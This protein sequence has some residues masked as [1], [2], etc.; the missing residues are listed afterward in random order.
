MNKILSARSSAALFESPGMQVPSMASGWG[1]PKIW[2][3]WASFWVFNFKGLKL[4]LF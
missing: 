2:F 1:A 3:H 4:E